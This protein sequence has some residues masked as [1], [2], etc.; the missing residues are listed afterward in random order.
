MMAP[1]YH[2]VLWE[3]DQEIRN[4]LKYCDD[5]WLQCEGSHVFLERLREMV[6]GSGVFRDG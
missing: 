2:S 3:I 4:K 1:E 6:W 5:E